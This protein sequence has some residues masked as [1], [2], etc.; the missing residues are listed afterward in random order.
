M[1]RRPRVT[2]KAAGYAL[3]AL[4]LW[5]IFG[6]LLFLGVVPYLVYAAIQRPQK[7]PRYALIGMISGIFIGGVGSVALYY[8]VWR[9]N[10]DFSDWVLVL[11][12]GLSAAYVGS[13]LGAVIGGLVGYRKDQRTRSTD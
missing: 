1:G 7:W 11:F 12:F 5:L 6:P 4:I 2:I 8:L 10:S 9:G 3:L 13:I